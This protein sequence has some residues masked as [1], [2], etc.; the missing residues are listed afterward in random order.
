MTTYFIV[1]RTELDTLN[2]YTIVYEYCLTT[3]DNVLVKDTIQTPNQRDFQV[4][5]SKK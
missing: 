5:N 2:L 1:V 4:L 3:L